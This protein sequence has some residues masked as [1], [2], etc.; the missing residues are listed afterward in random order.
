MTIYFLIS[1]IEVNGKIVFFNESESI[2]AEE[3]SEEET[4]VLRRK[5]KKKQGKRE[6]DLAGLPV[7]VIEYSLTQEELAVRFGE[8][9]YKQLP[10]EV[11]RRYDFTPAKDE[12]E[13]LHVKVYAGK[14]SDE[15]V[16]ALHPESLLR[17]SMMSPLLEAAVMNAP[18]CQRDA[19]LTSGTGV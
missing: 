2:A 13:E 1:F 12:V 11:Y 17:G 16:K 7:V 10:D 4:A 6:E 19:A 9:G 8:K 5:T 3:S 14:K 15:I 18:I